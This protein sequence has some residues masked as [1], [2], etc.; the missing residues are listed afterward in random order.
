MLA[1]SSALENLVNQFSLLPGI[2]RKTAQRLAMFVLKLPKEEVFAFAKALED[3]KTKMQSC[4]L[5]WNFSEQD[6]C[7]LCSNP[8]RDNSTICVVEEPKDVLLFE[9]TNAFRGLY[10]VL[11]GILSPLDNV[12]PEDLKAKELFSRINE[13]TK[14]IILAITPTIEGE[15]TILYLSKFLKPLGITVSRIARGIPIG[16]DLEFV[17]E[18]TLSTALNGRIV[19]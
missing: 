16:G 7:E 8:R 9:K 2:G 5:C 11:G 12:G 18:A 17:D 1:T 6:P 4:S 14:E 10:H 15:A 3:V 19:L 13:H